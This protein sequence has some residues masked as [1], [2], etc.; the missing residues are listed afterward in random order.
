MKKYHLLSVLILFTFKSTLLFS[1]AGMLDAGFGNGGKVLTTIGDSSSVANSVAITA[2]GKIV[3][4]G[5]SFLAGHAMATLIRYNSDGTIDTN[6][7]VK[8]KVVASFGDQS[9]INSIALQPDNKIVVG[10]SGGWIQ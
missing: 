9:A 2:E 7:G 4:G 8:G 3:V 5:N 1:Q 6:F 10:G